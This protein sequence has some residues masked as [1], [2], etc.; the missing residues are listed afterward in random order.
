MN[1]DLP[2]NAIER[3]VW[4]IGQST[5]VRL[6]QIPKER[7]HLSLGRDFSIAILNSSY[8]NSVAV[9]VVSNILVARSQNLGKD[10]IITKQISKKEE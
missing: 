5:Q 8:T 7:E 4:L 2:I 3:I 9:I 10:L 6:F 1:R